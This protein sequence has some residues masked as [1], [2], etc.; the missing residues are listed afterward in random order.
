MKKIMLCVFI[1]T[2]SLVKAQSIVDSISDRFETVAE[3]A[4]DFADTAKRKI[5][6]A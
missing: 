6:E 1:L 4:E 2:A 5:K 3:E